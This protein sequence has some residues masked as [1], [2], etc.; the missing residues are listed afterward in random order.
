MPSLAR[1]QVRRW[2]ADPG[3]VMCAL[4]HGKVKDGKCTRCDRVGGETFTPRELTAAEEQEAHTLAAGT[5]AAR[6]RTASVVAESM[7]QHDASAELRMT[8]ERELANKMAALPAVELTDVRNAKAMSQ[9]DEELHASFATKREEKVQRKVKHACETNMVARREQLERGDRFRARRRARRKDPQGAELH[10]GAWAQTDIQGRYHQ[11]HIGTEGE[12]VGGEPV[13]R[14]PVAGSNLAVDQ[15]RRDRLQDTVEAVDKAADKAQ[16]DHAMA[17]HHDGLRRKFELQADY[18]MRFTNRHKEIEKILGKKDEHMSALKSAADAMLQ[19]EKDGR[20][21]ARRS[22]MVVGEEREALRELHRDVERGALERLQLVLELQ[23]EGEERLKGMTEW[24]QYQWRSAVERMQMY[25][26]IDIDGPDA[27]QHD[28]TPLFKAVAR[29]N[30]D[31]VRLLLKYG[32]KP[33]LLNALGEAPIHYCW[34]AWDTQAHAGGAERR[35]QQ[36]CTFAVLRALVEAGAD[37]DVQDACNRRSALHLAA[38]HGPTEAVQYLLGRNC[39]TQLADAKGE[40][41]VDIAER[42]RGRRRHAAESANMLLR[43]TA[44]QSNLK[45]HEFQQQWTEFLR[46]PQKT[47]MG[48]TAK[49]VVDE[50]AN[51]DRDRFAQKIARRGEVLHHDELSAAYDADADTQARDL[52]HEQEVAYRKRQA[53]RGGVGAMLKRG[54]KLARGARKGEALSV[55]LDDYLHRGEGGGFLDRAEVEAMREKR[56]AERQT[57]GR[58]LKRDMQELYPTHKVEASRALRTEE[59][60]RKQQQYMAALRCDYPL[61]WRRVMSGIEVL[62]DIAGPGTDIKFGR[63]ATLSSI[64]HSGADMKHNALQRDPRRSKNRVNE[65]Y[66]EGAQLA[67]ARLEGAGGDSSDEVSSC[68]GEAGSGGEE[69]AAGQGGGGSGGVDFT[70][71]PKRKQAKPPPLNSPY[72]LPKGHTH[73]QRFRK[74]GAGWDVAPERR[75]PDFAL[76]ARA[77]TDGWKFVEGD[78]ETKDGFE[79]AHSRLPLEGFDRAMGKDPDQTTKTALPGTTLAIAME[80]KVQKA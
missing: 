26:V 13:T 58:E 49:D 18:E 20:E 47:L 6:Q 32:A 5:G 36:E 14:Y 51:E 46:D 1:M 78:T 69:G 48:A 27:A 38:R 80:P 72:A 9:T 60:R 40:R 76:A 39:S 3:V 65:E 8:I 61:R 57:K 67:L 71:S 41:P 19:A 50:L 25:K 75:R 45:H 64:L 73:K 17:S 4:C 23:F 74:K 24:E 68:D 12:V 21:K 30:L 79:D 28:N 56:R 11:H 33:G 66:T 43:W 63:P 29:G 42:L 35:S 53:A 16:H 2:G 54:G 7:G 52:K 15:W 22:S 31:V 77:P 62:K 59:Q 55:R 70:K 10:A 37:V 34:R 44:V